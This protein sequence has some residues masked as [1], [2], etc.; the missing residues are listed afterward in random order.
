MIDYYVAAVP[1]LT[2]YDLTEAA[3]WHY[4]AEDASGEGVLSRQQL[5]NVLLTAADGAGVLGRHCIVCIEEQFYLNVAANARD[6][7]GLEDNGSQS[8]TVSELM[9]KV[10]LFFAHANLDTRDFIQ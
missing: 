9:S 5:E 6:I 2:I 4:A 3:L 8:V 7:I 10:D 1:G